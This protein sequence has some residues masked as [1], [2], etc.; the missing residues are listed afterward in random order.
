LVSS[1]SRPMKTW[2]DFTGA[3]IIKVKRRGE[4]W[5]DS[6]IRKTKRT[7]K[8]IHLSTSGV[9]QW[10][11]SHPWVS[12]DYRGEVAWVLKLELKIHH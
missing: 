6:R 3:Y 10:D 2:K 5:R 4:G 9:Y 1:I 7:Q 11:K 8:G 12:E